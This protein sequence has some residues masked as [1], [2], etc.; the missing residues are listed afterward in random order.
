MQ[1]FAELYRALEQASDEV[2]RRRLLTSYLHHSDPVESA[3]AIW[4]LSQGQMAR[5]A[6][7]AQQKRWFLEDAGF[8]EWLFA[9]CSRLAADVLEVIALILPT[10]DSK[11]Q[12]SASRSLPGWIEQVLEPLRETSA[13]RLKAAIFE[14]SSQM[15]IAE[16]TVF[17]RLLTGRLRTVIA[18]A[19]VVS[20]MSQ[21]SGLPAD[22][23][24]CRMATPWK[25][26]DGQWEKL[27]NPDV[28]DIASVR[29]YQLAQHS[30]ISGDV[31]DPQTILPLE[32]A[33]VSMWSVEQQY[34]GQRVQLIR[35][36]GQTVLWNE[37]GRQIS[38]E[39]KQLLKIGNRCP[40]G[41]VIEAVIVFRDANGLRSSLA[42]DQMPNTRIRKQQVPTGDFCLLVLDLL[43]AAGVDQRG[44]SYLERRRRL[45]ALLAAVDRTTVVLSQT[46][47]CDTWQFAG[48]QR[49]RMRGAA[50]SGLWLRRLSAAY[51]EEASIYVWRAPPFRCRAVLIY[52]ET[53]T[54]QGR[55]GL[56]ELTFA[57][58]YQGQLLPIAKT[59]AD[60]A[61]KERERVTELMRTNR[62]RRY[63]PVHSVKA[64]LVFELSFDGLQAKAR[65]PGK[66][67]LRS[68]RIEGLCENLEPHQADSLE[69]LLALTGFVEPLEASAETDDSEIDDHELGGLFAAQRKT[70][71]E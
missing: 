22:V 56:R 54:I 64:D 41:T 29:P 11:G 50:G 15:T 68:P 14:A 2:R 48:A 35:R 66:L 30:E 42:T 3:W 65:S 23:I 45:E 17:H 69:T 36:G 26:G 27:V 47:P 61:P 71:S 4:L 28:T 53:D 52:L 58:W 44:E 55:K 38:R 20:A 37:S 6:S 39:W 59:A 16:R 60:V 32:Y 7:S 13:Q 12:R 34:L 51:S 5:I 62:I 31:H 9:E 57:V 40:E 33:D 19:E 43:E 1:R 8:P 70:S 18:D 63:G 21:L 25:P 46:L 24:A 49:S 67:S 10:S